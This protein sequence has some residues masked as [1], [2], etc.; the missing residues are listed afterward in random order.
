MNPP[1]PEDSPAGT[2]DSRPDPVLAV[3]D[4][5][6]KRTNLR[7]RDF[8]RYG[9]Y[10]LLIIVLA[11]T[12]AYAVASRGN[13][14]YGAR[15]QILFER[16]TENPTGFLRE[17]RDLTTQLVT[18]RSRSV[19]GPVAAANGLSVDELAK[20]VHVGIVDSSEIIS[21]QVDDRSVARGK[22]L[23][24]AITKQYLASA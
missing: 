1:R 12:A 11:A 18:L 19:L 6:P 15:T 23:A 17:D 20:K 24:G 21:V 7:T 9:L 14:V 22:R 8:V 3:V 4:F 13:R 5:E 10:S 16:R 2:V